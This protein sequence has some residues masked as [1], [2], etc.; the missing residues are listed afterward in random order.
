MSTFVRSQTWILIFCGI[1]G[2]GVKAQPPAQPPAQPA[3]VNIEVQKEDLPSIVQ[4][5]EVQVPTS[6]SKILSRIRKELRK[7]KKNT[8]TLTQTK[9]QREP[10]DFMD[11]DV[12]R[13][14][15][16]DAKE[17]RLQ[18]ASD[19]RLATNLEPVFYFKY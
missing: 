11:I 4:N 6:T 7:L 17:L 8:Q 13:Q 14:R 1:H 3:S 5:F 18:K 19:R 15:K 2:R 10:K 16:K 12:I 9:T